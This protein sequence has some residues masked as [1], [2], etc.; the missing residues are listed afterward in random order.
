MN[1][2]LFISEVEKLGIEVTSEKLD[3][4]NLFYKLLLEWNEKIN[5]TTIIEEE[6]VYLKHFYDSLTLF[7]DVDLN[8]E[9][10]I[11]D[12]G[13]GAGFPGVV[14]K[15]FFPNISI[16]LIDSLNKRI[17]YLN[18]IIDKLDLKN[19][20][21]IHS[22]MEDFSRNHEEEFDYIT[23]RAVSQLPILCEI[24]VKSLKIGGS[25]VFMKANCEEELINIENK[26]EKLGLKISF[27]DKFILPIENSN[28]SIIKIDKISKTNKLYPRTIDKIKKNPL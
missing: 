8:K 2:E 3:K 5:L 4:L 26:I 13:S 17:I 27:V 21:A 28:R 7:R 14:L 22:R 6:T 16:T 15:I 19:I 9:I 20:K 23:A 11:C 12:V 24:S 18:D 10:N 25:L 1:K